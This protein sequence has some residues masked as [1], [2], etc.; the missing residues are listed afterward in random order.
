M[1]N[2]KRL[3]INIASNI[4]SF[5]VQLGISFFLTPIITNKGCT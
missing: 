2:K 5:F 4:I 1:E 3:L